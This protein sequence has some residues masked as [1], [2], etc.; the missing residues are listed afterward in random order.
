MKNVKA[1][2]EKVMNSVGRV[3]VELLVFVAGG[4]SW[5]STTNI[6]VADSELILSDAI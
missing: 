5:T 2:I 6:C 1:K 4:L 3:A